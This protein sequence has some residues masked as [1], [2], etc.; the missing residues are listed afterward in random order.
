[1]VIHKYA[2][3]CIIISEGGLGKSYLVRKKLENQCK[4]DDYIIHSGHITPLALYIMLYKNHDKIIV[5]DDVEELL[6]NDNAVGI[7][8]AGLWDVMGDGKR[9]ITWAST[10]ESIFGNNG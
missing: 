4:Q 2:P 8:K 6:K 5:L 3:A 9:E 1:M 7:L 10:S